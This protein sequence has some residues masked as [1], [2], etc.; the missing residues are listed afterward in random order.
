MGLA[1]LRGCSA[2]S[3]PGDA[4]TPPDTVSWDRNIP[5]FGNTFPTP[6]LWRVLPEPSNGSTWQR[7]PLPRNSPKIPGKGF[8]SLSKE[9]HSCPHPTVLPEFSPARFAF[10]PGLFGFTPHLQRRS[11]ASPAREELLFSERNIHLGAA[12]RARPSPPKAGAMLRG[13]QGWV[14]GRALPQPSTPFTCTALKTEQ[15][16][17]PPWFSFEAGDN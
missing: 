7:S 10:L 14:L 17:A 16:P 9:P 3:I 12:C 1:A 4:Q 11:P 2:V 8:P 5:C 15:S 6:L 13:A